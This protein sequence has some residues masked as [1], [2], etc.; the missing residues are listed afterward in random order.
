MEKIIIKS[1][2]FPCIFVQVICKI[3]LCFVMKMQ[4]NFAANC[5]VGDLNN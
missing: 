4:L 3:Q 2:L 1:Y 5:T